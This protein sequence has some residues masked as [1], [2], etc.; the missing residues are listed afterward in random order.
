MH[1]DACRH[2]FSDVCETRNVGLCL[3][4]KRS[5]ELEPGSPSFLEIL[6]DRKKMGRLGQT[7]HN[8]P[9]GIMPR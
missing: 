2:N 6:T 9:D 3:R 1:C 4:M 7:I 5:T 8:N